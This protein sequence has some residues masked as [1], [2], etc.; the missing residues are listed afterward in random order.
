[1]PTHVCEAGREQFSYRGE[2]KPSVVPAAPPTEEVAGS[3]E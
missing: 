1:V 3:V 2:A